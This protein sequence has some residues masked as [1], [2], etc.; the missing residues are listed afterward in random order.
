[1]S[2]LGGKQTLC[3]EISNRRL[4]RTI[5]HMNPRKKGPDFTN[6]LMLH[7][8]IIF[9]QKSQSEK[10]FAGC[11]SRKIRVLSL[12]GSTSGIR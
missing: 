5:F 2:T 1:M 10:T 9:F 12:H 6:I 3:M 7:C 4:D 8:F 11:H